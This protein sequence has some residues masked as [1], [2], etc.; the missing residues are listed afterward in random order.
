[1]I[2]IVAVL[3][4]VV[5]YCAVLSS[6][7]NRLGAK[8]QISSVCLFPFSVGRVALQSGKGCCRKHVIV[9]I[10]RSVCCIES[11]LD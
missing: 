1:M 7:S 9:A 10:S 4:I 3:D 11:L 2:T 8:L 5:S 6:A